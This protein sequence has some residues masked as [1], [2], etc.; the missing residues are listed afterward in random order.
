MSALSVCV[1]TICK[2]EEKFID[3]WFQSVAAADCIVVVDTGSTDQSI[4]KLRGYPLI[5]YEKKIEPFRF[6]TARNL[7]L[8]L[9]PKDID[10]CISLDM[11]EVLSPSWYDELLKQWTPKT[12][13]ASCRFVWHFNDQGLED[14]VFWAIRIHRRHDYLW[15]HSIHEVLTYTRKSPEHSLKLNYIQISHLPDPLKKRDYLP[16]LE[17][18]VKE[19]PYNARD[20]FYLGREYMYHQR[21]H[22]CIAT[23]SHYLSLPYY[24]REE[25]CTA[26]RYIAKS[27]IYLQ[28]LIQGIYYLEKAH[29]ICPSLREPLIEL[30]YLYYQQQNWIKAA[31]F[32][33]KALKISSP[34]QH[35][36]NEGFAW[37]ATPYDIGSIAHFHLQHYEQSL[38]YALKCLS[39]RPHETRYIE[40]VR[41]IT[42][43][44]TCPPTSPIV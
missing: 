32:I 3:R 22:D 36:L 29:Q 35:F 6:D 23:L 15:T 24:W 37:D 40:N 18:A 19:N 33:D 43:S 4:E 9:I 1:Y 10:I 8:S 16:M 14:G 31:Y 2:N 38:D 41:L 20:V 21:W 28:Q 26:L 17:R 7:A 27:Y 42:S 34:S 13:C 30:G 11:D 25:R 12:S 44:M 39:Y 5:L